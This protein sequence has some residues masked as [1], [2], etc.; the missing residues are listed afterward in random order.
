MA[1]FFGVAAELDLWTAS[2]YDI[3]DPDEFNLGLLGLPPEQPR[4]PAYHAI[5]LAVTPA[6]PERLRAT[7]DLPDL[8][9]YAT[10]DASGS[11]IHLALVHWGASP[12]A[13]ALRVENGARTDLV[14]ELQVPALSVNSIALAGASGQAWT[15]GRPQHSRQIGPEPLELT[16]IEEVRESVTGGSMPSTSSTTG[17]SEPTCID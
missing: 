5:E 15:Y 11:T 1:D 4:R 2:I 9:A 3:A 14:A 12:L 7:S 8:R 13:V 6:G 16:C 10:R 17:G